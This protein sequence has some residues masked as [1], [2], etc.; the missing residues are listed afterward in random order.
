MMVAPGPR[1][2]VVQTQP[3]AERRAATHLVRQG[4]ETY[5]PRYLKRRRHARRVDVV[6]TPLFPRYV[7]VGVDMAA[8]RW[9]SI[10]STTGVARL[11]CNGEDPAAVPF[12]IVEKL[13]AGEDASGFISL[14]VAPRFAP[15]GKIRILDGVF[16]TRHGLID[17]MTDHQ[18]VAILLDLLGRKVRVVLDADLIATV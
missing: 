16:A 8:Q 7:F 3:N 5:F 14:A 15:G 2:Y 12:G 11:V 1:W 4:F 13:K 6:P 9:R 18:R 10:Q 17:S